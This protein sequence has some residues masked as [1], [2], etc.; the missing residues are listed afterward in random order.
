MDKSWMNQCRTSSAYFKE[1]EEFLD[2]VFANA[3]ID[4]EINF[5]CDMCGNSISV[6]QIDA[7]GHLICNGFIRSYTEWIAHWEV[8]SSAAHMSR[9]HVA[10]DVSDD[11]QGILHDR[12]HVSTDEFRDGATDVAMDGP[13]AEAKKFYKLLCVMN[14]GSEKACK[15]AKKEGAASVGFCWWNKSVRCVFKEKKRLPTQPI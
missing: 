7:C 3:S 14:G 2:F 5:H 15:T 1:V 12:F 6:L 13:N 10:L 4:G 9:A 11:M 8:K